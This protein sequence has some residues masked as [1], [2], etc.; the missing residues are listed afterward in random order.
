LVGRGHFCGGE[1]VVGLFVGARHE[2]ESRRRRQQRALGTG[3]GPCWSRARC[4]GWPVGS[5]SWAEFRRDVWT[6]RA[7]SC[8]RWVVLPGNRLLRVNRWF[9]LT[10]PLATGSCR[11]CRRGGS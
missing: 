6:V 2:S 5:G 8:R 7:L 4:C 1:W 9:G 10:Q 3:R 11:R